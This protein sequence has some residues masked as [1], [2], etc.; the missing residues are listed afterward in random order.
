MP[1]F[2]LAATAIVAELSITAFTV[3]QVATVLSLTPTV[4]ISFVERASPEAEIGL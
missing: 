4:G 3:A 2:T 1:I